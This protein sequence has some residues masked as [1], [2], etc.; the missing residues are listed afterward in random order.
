MRKNSQK[1]SFAYQNGTDWEDEMEIT[2]YRI[3]RLLAPEMMIE[4]TT[5]DIVTYIGL[6][7]RPDKN[8]QRHD[9]HPVPTNTMK[10]CISDFI[11]LGLFEPSQRRHTVSDT[12]EYWTLTDIGREVY[13]DIRRAMLEEGESES[14]ITGSAASESDES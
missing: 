7:L 2:L 12:N 11:A 14:T 4:K 9:Q 8:R 5:E 13:V 3:F 6:T 10:R 1:I